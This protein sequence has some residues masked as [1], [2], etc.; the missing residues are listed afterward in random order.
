M[1]IILCIFLIQK[2]YRMCFFYLVSESRLTLLQKK[3][4]NCGSS[5]GGTF[6]WQDSVLVKALQH[7]HWMLIDNVNFCRY[8]H[9]HPHCFYLTPKS[10]SQL[11]IS[12]DYCAVVYTYCF[13]SFVVSIYKSYIC[14]YKSYILYIMTIMVYSFYNFIFF[15]FGFSASVLDRLNALLEPNGE[16]VINE[17]GVIDG[18]IPTI[19]P[20][21][22]FR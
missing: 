9:S 21:P 22:N 6:E 14:Y 8:I 1:I 11:I 2:L 10:H 17:K 19:K 15:V 18:S 7:G 13:H 3:L 20:H 5:Q 12:S 16:L 4:S